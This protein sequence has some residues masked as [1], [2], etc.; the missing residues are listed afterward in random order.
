MPALPSLGLGH[1]LAESLR[2]LHLPPVTLWRLHPRGHREKRS[3]GLLRGGPS[4]SYGHAPMEKQVILLTL[5]PAGPFPVALYVSQVPPAD[6]YRKVVF[7]IGCYPVWGACGRPRS[8]GQP[9]VP[10]TS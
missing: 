4:A 9:N 8:R 3:L 5:V 10:P 7:P 1:S 2:F 6:V